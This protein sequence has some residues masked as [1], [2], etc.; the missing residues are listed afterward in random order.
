MVMG[1]SRLAVSANV[2]ADPSPRLSVNKRDRH[3][4]IRELVAAQAADLAGLVGN[5]PLEALQG[6]RLDPLDLDRRLGPAWLCIGGQTDGRGPH[7]QRQSC[8][9]RGSNGHGR[10]DRQTEGRAGEVPIHERAVDELA[11][12]LGN[13]DRNP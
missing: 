6:E 5:D 8:A 10:R 7:P 12:G 11:A 3:A 1:W 2:C 13:E 4:V 9:G